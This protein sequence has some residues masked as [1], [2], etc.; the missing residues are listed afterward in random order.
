[1]ARLKK[2]S[3]TLSAMVERPISV[4]TG[5]PNQGPHY[6]LDL[7]QV[8][9]G[10]AYHLPWSEVH[11]YAVLGHEGGHVLFPAS[12][13]RE[14]HSLAN[15]IDDA[16]Q[17]RQ[18]IAIKPRW[19]VYF[20]S[21]AISVIANRCYDPIDENGDLIEDP[22][23]EEHFKPS[24]W[25]LLFFR[26]HLTKEVHDAANDALKAWVKRNID[27][28][29]KDA[30][31]PKFDKLVKSGLA[32]TRL[33]N[34]S[35]ETLRQWC[36]LFL[37]VFPQEVE[38]SGD[39]SGAGGQSNPLDQ[40]NPAD[41][42]E[43]SEAGEEQD[44]GDT[45]K[46][47]KG[48]GD[49]EADDK[50]GDEVS[51]AVGGVAGEGDEEGDE[52]DA[53]ASAA[54]Q[55]GDKDSDDQK[56][57]GGDSEED[58]EQDHTAAEEAKRND[59][60]S[61]ALDKL[62]DRLEQESQKADAAAEDAMAADDES[63]DS[64]SMPGIEAGT[65]DTVVEKLPAGAVDQG[66]VKKFNRTL[67]KLRTFAEDK[68]KT[69]RRAGRIAVGRVVRK[70]AAGLPCMKPF[71]RKVVRKNDV[72]LSV[73]VATDNSVSTDNIID[74]LN[75]FT[76]NTIYALRKAKCESAAVVWN[77]SARTIVGIEDPISAVAWKKF[78]PSGGTSLKAASNEC[79]KALKG[80]RGT[81]KLA[82]I[83][84]D[85]EVWEHEVPEI[86]DEL[87]KAG[88]QGALL[89]SLGSKVPRSGIVDTVVARS[90]ESVATTFD[91]WAKEEFAK[92][93]GLK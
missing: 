42:P 36:A 75:Q 91:K 3:G 17:E 83:F 16:R 52:S 1:M 19:E 54:G 53:Q 55:P 68:L 69:E 37:E 31:K 63:D 76:H 8:H 28:A 90:L 92:A 86:S 10:E 41:A 4:F 48:E 18:V 64:G 79:I 93:E 40:D 44:N 26:T 88:F 89:V 50:K 80:A 39:Q 73:V 27:P 87:K 9:M 5:K 66:F 46:N 38:D 61:D 15:M 23:T 82:F 51:Q 24:L 71:D 77:T 57:K 21:L 59:E 35:E 56:G 81:R 11:Q 13:P 60:L 14:F 78:R 25:A 49:K 34:V 2:A 12:Y 7:D 67:T 85:G 65:V 45:G 84:T 6:R 72:P 62:R 33:K 20:R 32:I 43:G 29:D 70:Q 58:E 74:K 22:W 47:E 30:W